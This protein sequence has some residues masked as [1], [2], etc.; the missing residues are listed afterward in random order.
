MAQI[1]QNNNNNQ[2]F[3]SQVIWGRLEMKYMSKKNRYKIRAKKKGKTKV[4][5]NQ[6]K[7]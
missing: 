4:D 1:Y 3:Y 2:A 7:K 6:I 5:K